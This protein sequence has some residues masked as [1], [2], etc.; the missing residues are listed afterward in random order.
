[1]GVNNSK[2][3]D[4][5]T[6]ENTKEEPKYKKTSVSNFPISEEQVRLV[7]ESWKEMSKLE[8]PAGYGALMMAK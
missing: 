1:M 2:T 7:R 3:E 5:K 4:L 8:H 6:I